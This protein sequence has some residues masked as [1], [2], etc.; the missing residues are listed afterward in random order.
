MACRRIQKAQ[1]RA[2]RAFADHLEEGSLPSMRA[3]MRDIKIGAPK[4]RQVRQH[5]ASKLPQTS[6]QE[7]CGK[8][9]RLCRRAAADKLISQIEAKRAVVD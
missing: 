9:H 7:A 6:G 5:L 4:A 3:I 1:Q 2:E 8:A